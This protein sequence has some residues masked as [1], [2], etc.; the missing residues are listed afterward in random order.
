MSATVGSLGKASSSWATGLRPVS[1]LYVRKSLN[2]FK[3]RIREKTRRTRGDSLPRV[4]ASL[5]PML[6]GW[7]GYLKHAHPTTFKA[8]D[9]F[10]RR[11]LRSMLRK[12]QKRPGFGR[13]LADHQRWPNAFFA[14]AGL[15]ALHTAWQ[16]ARYPR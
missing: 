9:G 6:R 15:L 3:D 5:N 12:Q 10:I 16:T 11:R 2:R 8:L 1:A 14:Q 4:I 7:F 13:C